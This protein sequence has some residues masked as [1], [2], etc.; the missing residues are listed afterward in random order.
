MPVF[1][2]AEEM[3]YKELSERVRQYKE[4]TEGVDTMCDILDEMRSEERIKTKIEFAVKMI[5]DGSLPLE[6]IAEY[7]GLSIEE[8]RELAGNKSA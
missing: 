1:T 3:C 8:V 7:S 2:D 5:K 4:T 6:K